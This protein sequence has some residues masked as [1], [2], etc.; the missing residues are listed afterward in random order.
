MKDQEYR[1][2]AE[3]EESNWWFVAKRGNIRYLFNEYAKVKKD[4]ILLDVGCG[5]GLNSEIFGQKCLSIG[6]DISSQALKSCRGKKYKYLIRGDGEKIPIAD[7]SVDVVTAFDALE[8]L[9]DYGAIRGAYRILK[10]GGVFIVTVPAYAFLW[11]S[12]DIRLG[13][14][15]RYTVNDLEAKLKR[16]GFEI[17]KITYINIFLLPFLFLKSISEKYFRFIAGDKE[18]GSVVVVNSFL[19]QL[20]IGLLAIERIIWKGISFPCG[21]S[22][23]CIA[24]KNQTRSLH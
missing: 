5:T 21:T 20:L 19:N 22:I 12:R 3:S 11:T 10:L 15:R 9:G 14:I 6:L 17:R 23:L 24:E 13:H 8:H 2:H 1:L 18:Q 7:S 4:I 16:I